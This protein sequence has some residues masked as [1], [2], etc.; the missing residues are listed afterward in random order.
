MVKKRHTVKN[1][2]L[3]STDKRVLFVGRTF[4][5]HNHDYAMLKAEFPPEVA[6]F[7][8]LKIAVDLGYQGIV[9]DYQGE[10]ID[11]PHKKPRKSK[12]NPD[13]SLTPLQRQ[14]NQSLA[15]VRIYVE[16]AIG[17]IKRF[18]ILVHP[19]RNRISGFVHQ[20]ILICSALWNFSL[21]S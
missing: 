6:W 19:F 4:T 3:S 10:A 7:Q 14:A 18:N 15:K 9:S 2:I 12:R 8:T 11:I 1:T 17:G 13:T 20:V 16:H 5:G 21:S